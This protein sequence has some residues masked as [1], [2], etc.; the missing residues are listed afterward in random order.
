[1][2]EYLGVECWTNNSVPVSSTP[3]GSKFCLL[4]DFFQRLLMSVLYKSS[5]RHSQI[6][7]PL[8]FRSFTTGR[9]RRW[10]LLREC[11]S[12]FCGLGRLFRSKGMAR[13]TCIRLKSKCHQKANHDSLYDFVKANFII[14]WD[15]V[16]KKIITSNYRH[17][18]ILN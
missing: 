10:R 8:I 18:W 5:P 1:M 13:C 4:V 7:F 12:K 16:N 2:P 3:I 11:N 9:S 6:Q 17:L 15:V 14:G